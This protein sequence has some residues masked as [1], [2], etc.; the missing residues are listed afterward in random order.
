VAADSSV[1][2]LEVGAEGG[3][4]T[5]IGR[6]GADGAWRFARITIDQS[7]ELF[8]DEDVP[9]TAPDLTSLV[10]VDSWEAG[11]NLMDRYPWV[12]LSPVYVHPAFVERVKAALEERLT[13][14]DAS[15]A[16]DVRWRWGRVFAGRAR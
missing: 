4:V 2:V 6:E 11:L 14:V 9:I 8:G 13:N 1:V 16:E 15:T 5:L 10:W 7:W 3:S 12:R